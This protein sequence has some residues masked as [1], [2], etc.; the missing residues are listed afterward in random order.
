MNKFLNITT[1]VVFVFL[2]SCSSSKRQIKR[3]PLLA[4]LRQKIEN[5]DFTVTSKILEYIGRP[6]ENHSK[7]R[8]LCIKGDSLISNE[9]MAFEHNS[10]F[11]RIPIKNSNQKFVVE[12]YNYKIKDDCKKK[13]EVTFNCKGWSNVE[14]K[15]ITNFYK[16]VINYDGIVAIYVDDHIIPSIGE[17]DK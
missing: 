8:I 4:D 14:M 3:D 6:D 10:G 16:M 5:R 13:I 1:I 15:F 11:S 9:N 7:Q 17:I 12:I 2:V